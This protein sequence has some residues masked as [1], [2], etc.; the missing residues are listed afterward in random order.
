MIKGG[1][2]RNR[3]AIVTGAASGIGL[4]TARRFAA[5]GNRLLLVDQS[6][7]V[8]EIASE[9]NAATLICDISDKLAGA[10]ITQACIEAYGA[11]DILVNV[12]G[13]GRARSLADTD[14]ESLDRMIGINLTAVLSL[15][16]AVMAKLTRPG[17]IILNTSSTLG[18]AG[19]PGAT[20]YS[21]AKAGIAQFTRQLAAD[22]GPDGIR[23]NAVAPGAIETP[24][25][26]DRIMGDSAY[27]RAFIE[28]APLRRAGKPEEVAALFAFLAS[29]ESSF[30]TGQVIAVDGGWL[31]SRH[32]PAT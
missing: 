14:D 23:V 6:A 12:A 31:S 16:R 7:A 1:T 30:I 8:K 15:T 20:A 11:I 19:Y 24:L 13:I 27:R 3:V 18:L 2:I 17:G 22:L 4:A 21:V 25:T 26:Q 9:L 29:D 32:V 28:A 5:D 10:S